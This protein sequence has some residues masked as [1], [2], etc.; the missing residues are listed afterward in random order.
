MTVEHHLLAAQKCVDTTLELLEVL[1]ETDATIK[2][3]ELLEYQFDVL[4]CLIN[5]R[6]FGSDGLDAIIQDCH[7]I[8]NGIDK[9]GE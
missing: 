7:T 1:P 6:H 8:I 9:L 3:R 2:M 4:S 5:D